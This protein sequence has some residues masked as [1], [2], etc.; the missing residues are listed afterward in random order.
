M[1]IVALEPE[2]LVAEAEDVAHR[3]VERDARRVDMLAFFD[4]LDAD[5]FDVRF[6]GFLAEYSRGEG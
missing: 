5:R 1:R 4:A 2:V 3:R 6:R